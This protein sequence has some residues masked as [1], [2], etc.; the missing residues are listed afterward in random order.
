MVQQ[1]ALRCTR[2][3]LDYT[4]YLRNSVQAACITVKGA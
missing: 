3:Q 1:R 2:D 4:G